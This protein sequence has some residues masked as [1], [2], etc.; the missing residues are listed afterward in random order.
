MLNKSINKHFLQIQHNCQLNLREQHEQQEFLRSEPL[1]VS[2][3]TGERCNLK[4][5]FCT[6]RNERFC[7][8]EDL[9]L[10]RFLRFKAPL[11]RASR[12][13]LYGWG[14][15]FVNPEYGRIFD[16]VIKN[17][18]GIRIHISSNGTLLTDRWIKKLLR[19][20]KCL[21][22]ISL[23]AATP[24]TYA[25]VMGRSLFER[26]IGNLRNM[27]IAKEK[28]ASKNFVV[29]VSF[30]AVKSNVGDLPDLVLLCDAL[31]IKHIKLV[32]L[33]ILTEHHRKIFLGRDASRARSKFL[34]ARKLALARG[35]YLDSFIFHPVAYFRQDRGKYCANDLPSDLQPIWHQNYNKLFYPQ[36]GEC[37]EPWLSFLIRQNGDVFTCCRGREIMGN[38]LRQTYKEIWNGDKYRF[39]RRSINTF[40]PPVACR[41]CPV[42]LGLDIR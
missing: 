21:I 9:T 33:N 23:N 3:P 8:Y 16:Y 20:D 37:Y 35:I 14:E 29:M 15:P 30:V 38:L 1:Y 24:E 31:G 6:D 12:V 2:V 13:Q 34:A 11:I 26:V 22:N 10:R 41:E 39:Y 36:E 27:M 25:K 32:D 18:P 42:K 7:K 19:Y 5:T 4:C 17:F 28:V 40:R